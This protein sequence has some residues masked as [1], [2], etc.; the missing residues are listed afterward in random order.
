MSEDKPRTKMKLSRTPEQFEAEEKARTANIEPEKPSPPLT[1]KGAETSRTYVS[2]DADDIRVDDILED[3]YSPEKKRAHRASTRRSIAIIC[4]IVLL[5]IASA[6]LTYGYAH[7]YRQLPILE[8]LSWYLP[9]ILSVAL[10]VAAMVKS[11]QFMTR[12][13]SSLSLTITGLLIAA[14]LASWNITILRVTSLSGENLSGLGHWQPSNQTEMLIAYELNACR[15]IPTVTFTA[16]SADSYRKM[17]RR[18]PRSEW[19]QYFKQYLS[20]EEVQKVTPINIDIKMREV[21]ERMARLHEEQWA[22]FESVYSNPPFDFKV[23]QWAL[24]P[25]RTI[26]QQL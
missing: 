9:F 26:L 3:A 2:T 22:D 15:G 16:P 17:F 5:F 7:V 10:S 13:H 4:S 21:S 24:L 23:K 20:H 18:L 1:L 8:P 12:K 11:Y 19:K 6:G 14:G 25:Y